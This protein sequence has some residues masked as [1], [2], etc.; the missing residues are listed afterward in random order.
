MGKEPG[1]LEIYLYPGT[2][3]ICQGGLTMKNRYCVTWRQDDMDGH[4]HDYTECF[5]SEEARDGFI[6]QHKKS[7]QFISKPFIII[8]LWRKKDVY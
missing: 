6:V 1:S 8:N 2:H 4:S 7:A 3:P 5:D